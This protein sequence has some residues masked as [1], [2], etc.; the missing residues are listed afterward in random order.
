MRICSIE[1]C[2][3]KHHAKG[4][5]NTHYAR[6][7]KHESP[8]MVKRLHHDLTPEDRFWKYTDKQAPDKCWEWQGTLRSGYGRLKISGKHISCHRLS[9]QIHNG[10]IPPGMHV[11]HN[12]FNKQCVNPNHLRLGSHKENLNDWDF[13]GDRHPLSKV[14]DCVQSDIVRRYKSG[15]VSQQTL[16][17]E[18]V[19]LG[20]PI[21]RNAVGRWVRDE[22][23]KSS[24]DLEYRNPLRP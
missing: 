7:L 2:N 11:L 17:D 12:C 10:A 23:R 9:W 1:G 15:G 22:C 21:T 14:P 4:Y 18:L 3:K 8:I 5:C 6:W 13:T 20:W 19:A 16:A 24:L